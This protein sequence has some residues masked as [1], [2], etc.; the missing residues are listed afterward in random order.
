M[1]IVAVIDETFAGMDLAFIGDGQRGG[2]GL[3]YS[4]DVIFG[5]RNTRK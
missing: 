4:F 1:A 3:P 5:P 2:L